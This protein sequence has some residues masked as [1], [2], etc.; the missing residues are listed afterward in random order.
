MDTVGFEPTTSRKHLIKCEACALPLCQE[1]I[2]VLSTTALT[3]P[4][5]HPFRVIM[6]IHL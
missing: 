1:P 3:V 2:Y 6:M 5:G 4:L